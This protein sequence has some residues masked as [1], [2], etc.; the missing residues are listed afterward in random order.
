MLRLHKLQEKETIADLIEE[1]DESL[2][3]REILEGD[4]G[5]EREEGEVEGI[6]IQ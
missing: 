4:L 1:A 6:G 3:G 5:E 2:E